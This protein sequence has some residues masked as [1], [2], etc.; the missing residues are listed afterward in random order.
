MTFRTTVF[1]AALGAAAIGFAGTAA[2]QDWT[3]DES[4]THVLFEVSHMGFSTTH[5][6]FREFSGSVDLDEDNPENT[7]VDVTIDAAS[8]DT[9][10]EKRDEH[11]RNE[12]FFHVEKFP[13]LTF[14]ST[15]V[16]RTGEDTAKMTGDLTILGVTKPV[17][18]D[19]TLNKKAPRRDQMVAGFSATGT[20]KRSEFGLDYGVP[21]VSDEV[22][23][24]IETELNRPAE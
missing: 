21:A 13:E 15:K 6:G 2:A 8:I 4:H 17:T 24:T 19:V 16:E 5:G 1:A 3:I 18:L 10:H 12:D 9:W 23:I 22:K 20:L 14:K 7:K 11:L